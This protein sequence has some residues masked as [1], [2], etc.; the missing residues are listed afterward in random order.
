MRSLV[1]TLVTLYSINGNRSDKSV[2]QAVVNDLL[3]NVDE[4]IM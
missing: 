1:I 2:I 3:K 4:M